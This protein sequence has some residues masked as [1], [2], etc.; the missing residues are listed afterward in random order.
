MSSRESHGITY[1][2]RQTESGAYLTVLTKAVTIS[3]YV[4]RPKVQPFRKTVDRGFS[5]LKNAA[6]ILHHLVERRESA[7]DA[8][9][10]YIDTPLDTPKYRKRMAHL[11]RVARKA[12]G[13]RMLAA[14]VYSNMTPATCDALIQA[15]KED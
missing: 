15:C 1:I 11:Y 9:A 8:C 10:T 7:M 4:R 14:S 3:K 12:Q 2:I 13:G 5:H 6:R